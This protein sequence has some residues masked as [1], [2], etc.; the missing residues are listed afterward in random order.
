M[1]WGGGGVNV[2]MPTLYCIP[3]CT[4]QTWRGTCTSMQRQLHLSL[5]TELRDRRPSKRGDASLDNDDS[6]L[7]LL[8]LHFVAVAADRFHTNLIT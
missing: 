4:Y 1:G 7:D 2:T 6:L 8:L 5:R 3:Y